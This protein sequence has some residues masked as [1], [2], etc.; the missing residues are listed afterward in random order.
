V[1]VVDIRSVRVRV[2]RRVM[3]VFVDMGFGKIG[4]RR[5]RVRV[6]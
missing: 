6:V 5:M 1:A 4:A 3:I 2:H